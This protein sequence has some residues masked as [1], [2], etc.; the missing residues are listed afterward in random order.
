MADLPEGIELTIVDPV[1]LVTV[2]AGDTLSGL[3]ERYA[4]HGS[5]WPEIRALNRARIADPDLIDV[6]WVLRVPLVAEPAPSA[7]PYV[8]TVPASR[9]DAG[10]PGEAGGGQPD[11]TVAAATGGSRQDGVS[12]TGPG[13]AG[14]GDPR[15]DAVVGPPSGPQRAGWGRRATGRA[16]CRTAGALPVGSQCRSDQPGRLRLRDGE[17][18]RPRGPA[19]C[20][21]R[22]FR[23]DGRPRR[24]RRHASGD[25]RAR[26][27]RAGGCG[28]RGPRRGPAPGSA[29]DRSAASD[30][31][32]GMDERAVALLVGGLS[33]LTAGAVVGGIA[34]RR[35]L[36][37]ATRPL[38]RRYVQPGDDLRR[39]ETALAARASE[40]EPDL[41]VLDREDL[42]GRAM[43]H[44][45]RVVRGGAAAPAGAGRGRRCGRRVCIRPR[46][47]SHSGF[48]VRDRRV[49]AS[50]VRL[51]DLDDPIPWR[52]RLW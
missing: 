48:Q 2:R 28:S 26:S 7:T 52:T 24:R 21:S 38:G 12:A 23:R 17:P 36:Q 27:P 49:A 22:G 9:A 46:P 16:E 50:W 51:S 4:G 20:H 37:E 45:P 1:R 35:R 29:G 15:A 43:R 14:S 44:Q 34:L 25:V 40:H 11:E 31:P 3:A 32:Q 5:R 42:V 18:D 19:A 47:R 6:G 10:P 33:A 39:I 13:Y 8:G 30:A 41:P